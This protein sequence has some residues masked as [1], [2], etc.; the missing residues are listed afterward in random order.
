MVALSLPLTLMVVSTVIASTPRQTNSPG[1]FRRFRFRAQQPVHCQRVE[2]LRVALRPRVVDYH[3]FE[4][5]FLAV[6]R[7]FA[8]VAIHHE[9]VFRYRLRTLPWHEMLRQHISIE[10]GRIVADLD[11]K[12]AD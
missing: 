8:I 5:P 2:D 3:S 6:A 1:L 12:I 9:R 11:L 10:C 4:T 7:Q